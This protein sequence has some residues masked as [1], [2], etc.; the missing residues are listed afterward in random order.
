MSQ[1]NNFNCASFFFRIVA[2]II[3][4]ILIRISFYLA[5]LVLNFEIGD[6]FNQR[7]ETIDLWGGIA[8]FF[9]YTLTESSQLQGSL[10]KAIIGLQIIRPYTYQKRLSFSGAIGR[11]LAKSAYILF[12]LYVPLVIVNELIGY[13]PSVWLEIIKLLCI[14]IFLIGCIAPFR[15]S[16]QRTLYDR[17]CGTYVVKR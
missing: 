17:L 8:V 12:V 10:G 14:L 1:L 7:F 3:D 4:Y 15:S 9:Y 16:E 11:Q 6:Y 13:R 5:S 2:A